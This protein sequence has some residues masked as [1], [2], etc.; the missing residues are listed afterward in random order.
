MLGKIHVAMIGTGPL[1]NGNSNR[2]RHLPPAARCAPRRSSGS[3]SSP[4]SF[5][6]RVEADQG[7][8]RSRPNGPC[9]FC[10][11]ADIQVRR[12]HLAEAEA[13]LRRVLDIRSTYAGRTITLAWYCWRM[14]TRD[15][16]LAEM[17]QETSDDGR[18][19]GLAMAYHALGRKADSDAALARMVKDQADENAFG[20]AEVYAFRGQLDEAMQWLERA[21]AQKDPSLNFVKVDSAFRSLEADPRYKAFLRKMNLPE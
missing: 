17:Q 9:Q 2:Q 14:V 5:G 10:Y 3:F 7:F 21:Y 11:L 1:P 19:G 6:R 4:R 18:Q 13:A 15:A 20:I 8:N 12:G 16:A